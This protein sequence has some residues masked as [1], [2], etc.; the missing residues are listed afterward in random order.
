MRVDE[1]DFQLPDELIAQTPL[2]KR[3]HSRLLV[4]DK[5]KDCFL[6]RSFSDI[7]DYLQPQDVLVLNNTR[8]LPAR[9]FGQNRQSLGVVEILLLR[10]YG[11]GRWE[12]LVK[13]GKR[14]KVGAEIVFS[15]LLSCTVIEISDSGGRLVFFNFQGDFQ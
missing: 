12:V 1:F 13:P 3:D 10:P 5:T 11:E 4:V 8:V 15:P 7:V 14:A 2:T 9:L 6:D